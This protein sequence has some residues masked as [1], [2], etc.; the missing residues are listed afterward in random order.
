MSVN[1]DTFK[2]MK[3]IKANH[4]FD[5]V[6]KLSKIKEYISVVIYRPSD[7]SCGYLTKFEDLEEDT[8]AGE[9]CIVYHFPLQNL[10]RI[11]Q[12]IPLDQIH[13]TY[14]QNLLVKSHG[15]FIGYYRKYFSATS[16]TERTG[17]IF[18]LSSFVVQK[19]YPYEL[20][21]II[22]KTENED[23]SAGRFQ[24]I[25]RAYAKLK[26]TV[27]FPDVKALDDCYRNCHNSEHFKCNTYSYCQNGDCRV[28]SLLT[29]DSYNES[30]VEQDKSCSILSLNVIN[31][32]SEVS[33]KNLKHRLTAA[34]KSNIYSCA[35]YC[36][37]SLDCLSFQWGD[38]QCSFGVYYTDASAE[39]VDECSVYLRKYP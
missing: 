26:V 23:T 18:L 16:Y 28:S 14:L 8:K 37:A 10:Q 34:E 7:S 2:K 30:H 38:F 35:E 19:F 33:Q 22:D 20:V 11:D 27:T 24:Y 29:E 31:D 12:E 1:A 9:P 21:D 15:F 3:P 36:H 5:C 17:A 4:G 13:N 25:I 32:Y 39:Y 6:H